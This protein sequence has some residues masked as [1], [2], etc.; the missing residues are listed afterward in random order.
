MRGENSKA[1]SYLARFWGTGQDQG[2]PPGRSRRRLG[3]HASAPAGAPAAG[4]A[5]ALSYWS[6]LVTGIMLI[7]IPAG[8]V[9]TCWL[10]Y[11]IFCLK[12]V[13]KTGDSKSLVHA[14]TAVGP[15][16]VGLAACCL[17]WRSSSG[18]ID[19]PPEELR[20]RIRNLSQAAGGSF[21]P[22]IMAMP[23]RSGGSS[24]ASRPVTFARPV[25]S[26]WLAASLSPCR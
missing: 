4:R 19:H 14:A 1:S 11:L 16:A 25:L 18:G 21:S 3:A 24:A 7:A 17:R 6:A 8:T 13:G 5:D 2:G 9:V 23:L 20:E 12:L 22:T 10:A 26:A 15:S